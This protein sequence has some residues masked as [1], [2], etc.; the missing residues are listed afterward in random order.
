MRHCGQR[1]MLLSAS[2]SVPHPTLSRRRYSRPDVRRQPGRLLWQSLDRFAKEDARQA[3]ACSQCSDPNRLQH[4]QVRSTV[5][6]VRRR[7]LHW[8]DADDRV[9]FRVCVQVYKCLHNMAPGY[10]SIDTLPTR[11]QRSTLV[12]VT[13]ARLV[14]ANWT[15][16]VLIWLRTG[17]GRLPTPVPHLGT[18]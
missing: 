7:E 8:L 10:L 17:D 14:V 13:Y 15:F 2:T 9:Q 6:L 18:L 1:Q 16:Y 11:V 4:M 3:A 5:E 12:V